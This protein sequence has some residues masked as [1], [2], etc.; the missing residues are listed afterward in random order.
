MNNASKCEN[1]RNY[2][3]EEITED[4]FINNEGQTLKFERYIWENKWEIKIFL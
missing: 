4:H 1:L 3:F 2:E